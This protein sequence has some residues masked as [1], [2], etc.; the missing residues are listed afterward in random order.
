[1]APQSQKNLLVYKA[2]AGA[3]KTFTLVKEYLALA[4]A[5]T[6][7]YQHILAV[8]F[9]N[10]AA[11]E[12]KYRIINNLHQLSQQDKYANEPSIEHMLPFLMEQTGLNAEALELRAQATLSAILHNYSDFSILTIDRFF[13]R[14]LKT[15][16]RDLELPV[17]FEPETE[18]QKL[19]QQAVDL[20][21]SRAGNDNEITGTLKEYSGFKVEEGKNWDFST[22]LL[23]FCRDILSKEDSNT[24]LQK[25]EEITPKQFSDLNKTIKKELHRI[26]SLN[27][28]S[29][30]EFVNLMKQNH[31]ESDDLQGKSRGVLNMAQKIASG[32]KPFIEL[33]AN[34]AKALDNN[35][36][37]NKASSE[38]IS[39]IETL[40]NTL[41][42]QLQTL[43]NL[44]EEYEER[45]IL[46]QLL[47]KNI[48]PLSL[49]NEVF[50]TVSN[51]KSDNSIVFV[52]DFNDLIG[53]VVQNEAIP[54]IYERVGEKYHHFMIDEFQDTSKMQWSNLLPLVD[55]SLAT[56][57]KN[58]IVGDA[59]QAIYRW[60]NGNVE[61]FIMLPQ[62]PDAEDNFLIEE[63]QDTIIR[64]YNENHLATNFRS[65]REVIEFNNWFF[66]EVENRLPESQKSIYLQ[67]AQE[68]IEGNIGGGISIVFT[69]KGTDDEE[70]FERISEAIENAR[71]IGYNYKDMVVLSRSN[72]TGAQIAQYLVSQNYPVI[73]GES[74][75]LANYGKV[76]FLI[77]LLKC[78]AQP[79]NQVSALAVLTYLID[80]NAIQGD[81][82][83]I[84]AGLRFNKG[85]IENP[86]WRF[87]QPYFPE[88]RND[89]ALIPLYDLYEH[90]IQ[91]F[92]PEDE[93]DVY[94]QFFLEEVYVF[95]SKNTGLNGFIDYWNERS[96]KASLT[97]PDTVDAI[98]LMS[99]HKAKGLEFPVVIFPVTHSIQVKLT[100]KEVW[101]EPPEAIKDV[102]GDLQSLLFSL[103]K[104]VEGTTLGTLYESEKDRSISDNAN[105]LYVA[106]T[107]AVDQL[108]VICQNKDA[109]NP[110]KKV[111]L[112]G[113][114]SDFLYVIASTHPDFNAENHS[115]SI[116]PED[117]VYRK[118]KT[119][120]Q[121]IDTISLSGK[122]NIQNWKDS[123][124][125]SAQ[126]MNLWDEEGQRARTYGLVM[127][128]ILSE[129]QYPKDQEQIIQKYLEQGIINRQDL[130]KISAD[131]NH[132][133]THPRLAEVFSNQ[134]IIYNE[135]EI[136][137]PQQSAYRPDRVVIT[138][139]KAIVV[140]YKTGSK[141]P[142]HI[143]Q[144][145]G[146]A[147][148]L[149]EMG[150][151]VT[152]KLII[153]IDNEITIEEISI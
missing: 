4:L 92:F 127:H 77:S 82:S 89:L 49:L 14:I 147:K 125:L 90:F 72:N 5:G 131:I 109:F 10:K 11:N 19:Y 25:L 104:S 94:I 100:E 152:E 63:R 20:V 148:L 151:E 46:L 71:E 112:K 6:N 66:T 133:L 50:K 106:M 129:I 101:V 47:Q 68:F 79:D 120:D 141:K 130:E 88:I 113:E 45:Y 62:L 55:N 136:I 86:V 124:R 51:L 111:E 18:T 108:H 137:T 70:F 118:Q 23:E 146:Y 126:S 60:R 9:T 65:K 83:I 150:Y 122:M 91:V 93:R 53:N 76:Q 8:T 149:T 75:L 116:V 153:Y 139:K 26:S 1:M 52:S 7:N 3:G 2:S 57:R 134:A 44:K 43:V 95:S 30:G 61:Q 81:I 39:L 28:N 84:Y 87:L 42:T 58:L 138:G 96:K 24:H 38:K 32:E 142:S 144:I 64:N 132:I 12:M 13:H 117:G 123:V 36:A 29:A 69:E 59:K 48:Y 145:E 97:V 102:T 74:L 121:N 54:F 107:R 135:K 98:N 15:F 105:L 103:T 31:I 73:S 80:N 114:L 17:T 34:V 99:I 37:H 56:G 33:N 119:E 22:T 85:D 115:L 140:D 143:D 27:K 110:G 21:I 35:I 40:S 41:I 78:L 67:Q 16:A 128:A